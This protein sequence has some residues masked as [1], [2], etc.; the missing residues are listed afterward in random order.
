MPRRRTPAPAL[1]GRVTLADAT[2]HSRVRVTRVTGR[3]GL[4]QRLAALGVVPGVVLTVMKPH[5]PSVV[6]LG[7]ARIAIGHS[8]A[9][10]VEIEVEQ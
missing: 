2:R 4:I 6:A 8:A 1:D 5:G 10:A 7:G 3:P 9:G